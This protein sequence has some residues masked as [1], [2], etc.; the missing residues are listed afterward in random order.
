MKFANVVC[1]GVLAL[2]AGCAAEAGIEE[3]AIGTATED[4]QLAPDA[5]VAPH[6]INGFRCAANEVMIGSHWG[7]QQKSICAVLNHGYKVLS[8]VI[9]PACPLAP[10]P[11]T[12]V[13]SNPQVHGCPRDYFIQG[14][15]RVGPGDDEELVCVSLQTAD[16]QA[17]T[18]SRSYQDGRGPND[19]GTKSTTEYGLSPE[20]HVCQKGYAMAGIHQSQND[21]WCA[22]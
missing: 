11:C 17:L 19:N 7:S 9:D 6:V 4:L 20:M 22:N 18:Y 15:N 2:W 13:G 14:Y 12:K 1:V 10:R 3:T 21:L 5:F 8:Q 16:N